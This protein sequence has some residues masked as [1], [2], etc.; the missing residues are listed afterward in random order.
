MIKDKIVTNRKHKDRFFIF[1]FGNEARKEWTLSL[2][3]A[4]NG[5]NYKNPNDIHFNTIDDVIYMGMKNDISFIV[6]VEINVFEHQSSYNP[7]M[8]VRQLIYLAK[9][10]EGFLAEAHGSIYS[11]KLIKLPTP[12]FVVFYN[13]KKRIDDEVTLYLSDS[14]NNGDKADIDVR[15]RMININSDSNKK[16]MKLCK[17][18]KEY[19]DFIEQ[20]RIGMKSDTLRNAIDKAIDELPDDYEIKSII[21]KNKA[22]VQG[23]ILTEYGDEL[24]M[25]KLQNE[26]AQRAAKSASA[27]TKREVRKEDKLLMVEILTEELGYSEAKAKKLVDKKFNKR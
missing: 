8:P 7:N 1:L 19:A 18:L 12:K 16:L 24:Q 9:L 3:N 5:T 26:I 22:E 23:M 27:K 20:I 25:K 10:Y 17:P 6:D 2:Y 15:V 21:M 13:G 11:D 14:F 4:I